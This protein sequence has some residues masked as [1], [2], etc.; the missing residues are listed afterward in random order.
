MEPWALARASGP[1]D[2]VLAYVPFTPVPQGPGL[3]VYS[4]KQPRRSGESRLE[5]NAPSNH[6]ILLYL[7]GLA[8]GFTAYAVTGSKPSLEQNHPNSTYVLFSSGAGGEGAVFCSLF[9]RRLEEPSLQLS[10]IHPRE[11][12][13]LVAGFWLPS[14]ALSWNNESKCSHSHLSKRGQKPTTHQSAF[15][16][17]YIMGSPRKMLARTSG[18]T[19]CGTPYRFQ[20][21]A[22]L[23]TPVLSRKRFYA[24]GT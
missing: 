7:R 1:S 10:P 19:G 22:N 15:S 2:S 20:G 18:N 6:T 4:T 3:F 11:R 13:V 16:S 17:D 8:L 12:T 21:A 23:G 9:L 24:T 5:E 14:V